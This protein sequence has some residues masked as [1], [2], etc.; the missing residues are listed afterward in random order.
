M[1][2]Y[3]LGQAAKATGRNK[4]TIFQALKSGRMSAPKDEQGRYLIDPAELH[5]LYPPVS[6]NG[7]NSEAAKQFWTPS[8]VEELRVSWERERALLHQLVKEI[9][10]ERDRLLLLLP[11]PKEP[12]PVITEPGVAP[13]IQPKR[14]GIANWLGV[15]FIFAMVCIGLVVMV[16]FGVEALK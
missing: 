2:T 6:H 7:E 12:E 14:G 8:N 11:R 15:G 1:T 4:A 13:E 16:R 3:S 9:T 5:R 10:G